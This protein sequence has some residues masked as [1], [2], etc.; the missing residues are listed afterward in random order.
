[1]VGDCGERP[2]GDEAE[3]W[4]L[5]G[6]GVRPH[7]VP[8]GGQVRGDEGIAAAASVHLDADKR[9]EP[10]RQNAAEV[11][12]IGAS[13]AKDVDGPDCRRRGGPRVRSGAVH[14]DL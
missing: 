8:G 11:N 7:D 6:P 14:L 12:E 3:V 2:G 1:K 10:G 5:E 13:A 4:S 9:R